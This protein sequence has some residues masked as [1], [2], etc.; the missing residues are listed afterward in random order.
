MKKMFA[1]TRPKGIDEVIIKN[2]R[3]NLWIKK[4]GI[5]CEKDFLSLADLAD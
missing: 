3:N 4:C 5:D 2:S 1:A